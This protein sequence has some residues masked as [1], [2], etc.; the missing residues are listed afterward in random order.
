[1]TLKKVKNYLINFSVLVLFIQSVFINN[2]VHGQ[3]AT[4]NY[5]GSVQT[6]TVPPCVFCLNIDIRGAKGGGT[7]GN[8]YLGS[9]QGGNGARVLHPCIPVQPGQI[10]EIRVG[11]SP[12]NNLGG[13][14]GG[15][16]GHTFSTTQMASFGGGGATDIRIAPYTLANRIAVAGGGGG[17]AGGSSQPGY[18]ASGGGGGCAS[19]Q[20]GFGSVF[21]V[22]GGGGGTQAAGGNGGPPW[23]G[24]VPGTAGSIGQGGN[25]G[26]YS[27]A[28][29]GGGGGGYYGGGGG[30]SDNCCQGANGGGGGGGGSSFYPVGGVCTQGF[31]T[32]NGQLVI[33]YAAGGT[34]ITASNGGPY[35][36]GQTISLSASTGASSYSWVGP[37]GFTSNLQNP[38]IP[39]STSLDAGV[40]TL[41]YVT[42]ACN[43]ITT[44]TVVVNIPINPLFTQIT[45]ICENGQVPLLPISSND[46]PAITGTWSPSTISSAVA[47]SQT[48]SF[49]PALNFCANIATMNITILPNEI[50]TFSVINPLCINDAPPILQNPSTNATP[51]TGTW[52]PANVVTTSA[53]IFTYNFTPT[54]GQC[55][56]PTSFN[57][58][59]LN[60]TNPTFQQIGPLCQYTT[61]VTLP[62]SSTNAVP[63]TGTWIPNNINTQVPSSTV[64]NFTPDPFQCSSTG[65][66]TIVIDPLIIPQFAQ[67]PQ[68]CQGDIP[69]LIPTVSTNMPG[70]SGTWNPPAI[71][72][73]VDGVFTHSF[74]PDPN[75]CS[76]NAT[77]DIVII[78][79][80]PPSFIADTLSGCNPLSVNF[81]TINPVPGANYT[82]FWNNTEIGTGPN[83]AYTLNASGY[84]DITLEYE[85]SSCLEITTYNDYIF[86]ENDPV[87]SFTFSPAVITSEIE[88][89]IFVNS[90]LGAVGYLWDFGDNTSG[91]DQNISH[92][93]TGASD[94]ILV[95]LTANTPLGCFDIYE[96]TLV[97]LSE[98]IFYVPNTFTPDEDEHN[99]LWKPIF[100][101]G[102]DIYSFN[103]QIYNRWGEIIWETND[104]SAGWDGTYGNSSLKVPNGIYNW[105]IRYGS[106]I[107]DDKKEASGFV[108]VLY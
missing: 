41:N 83:L 57:I 108:N 90:S 48:Y 31:Q 89:I 98:A 28:S 46:N 81:T 37:N 79:A 99:Q 91:T 67:I 49:T 88:E 86:M 71:D 63:I 30:G 33:T 3:T 14:N 42:P 92:T 75:Q 60:Y 7:L 12:T 69:P 78:A 51:Y 24:G 18:Q 13:Y 65:Q 77:M 44:T 76:N 1:M 59:I 103:L 61:G 104:A 10:L 56:V 94:N 100:T 35:C 26:F 66:M 39:N 6:W 47:G 55:A 96:M 73:S 50:P 34:V 9:G 101:S 38:T 22:V 23:A 95:S 15:G 32:G 74:I 8:P 5:T 53:G 54:L 105:T 40:Y 43:G 19:G 102:F 62:G 106:K 27:S 84:H 82:W 87:A 21:T 2:S 45:P 36:V 17:R 20:Q 72:S 68:V 52:S 70:I 58:T 80:M 25:G 29:G 16:I 97:V 64:Y 93:Y 11:G 85:L 4:F 107:N